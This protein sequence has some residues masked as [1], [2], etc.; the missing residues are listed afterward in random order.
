MDSQEGRWAVVRRVESF[1]DSRSSSAPVPRD[2]EAHRVHGLRMA[3]REAISVEDRIPPARLAQDIRHAQEWVVRQACR[4]RDCRPSPRDAP[5]L[6]GAVP[7]S[8]I[9]MGPRKA[10]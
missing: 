7:A 2:R 5:A 3:V 4:L 9:N 1:A 10:R 6:L 8:V